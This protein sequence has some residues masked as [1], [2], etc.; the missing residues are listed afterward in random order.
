MA[1]YYTESL[2]RW[3]GRS[4]Q[5]GLRQWAVEIFVFSPN[6]NKEV[7]ESLAHG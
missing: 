6:L 3:R 5:I 4:V 2:W 7:T 1:K